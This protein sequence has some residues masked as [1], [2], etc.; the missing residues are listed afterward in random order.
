MKNYT[1]NLTAKDIEIIMS[2]IKLLPYQ[3]A[4]LLINKLNE[5]IQKEFNKSVDEKDMPTGQTTPKDEFAGD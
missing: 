5:Q 3:D 2:A 4:H 1:I